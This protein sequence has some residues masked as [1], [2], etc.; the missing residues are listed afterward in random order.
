MPT[1]SPRGSGVQ[2]R[3]QRAVCLDKG[4]KA[5]QTQCE[6]NSLWGVAEHKN[7]RRVCHSK[8]RNEATPKQAHRICGDQRPTEDGARIVHTP[9]KGGAE[10][11]RRKKTTTEVRRVHN[12]NAKSEQRI[13]TKPT[14]DPSSHEVGDRSRAQRGQSRKSDRAAGQAT[15]ADKR[16]HTTSKRAQRTKKAACTNRG[17][18]PAKRQKTVTTVDERPET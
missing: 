13:R 14:A 18:E 7:S 5:F 6:P 17:P 4:Q 10:S 16:T 15:H 1:D 12:A 8:Q 3:T 2:Q 9:P 11:N